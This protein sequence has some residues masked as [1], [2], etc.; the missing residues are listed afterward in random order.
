MDIMNE[1]ETKSV[2]W[3]QNESAAH[4]GQLPLALSHNIEESNFIFMDAAK[5]MTDAIPE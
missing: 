5:P 2:L 1:V 3:K 4:E